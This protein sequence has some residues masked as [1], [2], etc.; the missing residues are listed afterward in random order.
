MT[1][2]SV[3]HPRCL[4]YIPLIVKR[5]Q[6]YTNKSQQ[7]EEKRRKLT[8][9]QP[10]TQL[11][12]ER[13]TTLATLQRLT[14]ASSANNERLLRHMQTKLRRVEAAQQRIVEKR[15]GICQECQIAIDPERLEM[16]P[17]AEYCFQCQRQLENK[18]ASADEHPNGLSIQL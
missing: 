10:T 15:Y 1:D 8:N 11:E 5:T 3:S 16:L 17:Y 18:P 9:R 12:Q 6:L 13:V 4:H 2:K 7:K 14:E